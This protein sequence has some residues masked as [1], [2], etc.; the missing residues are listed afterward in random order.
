MAESKRTESLPQVGTCSSG[1]SHSSFLEDKPMD[2]GEG[3]DQLSFNND[4]VTVQ[5]TAME[6]EPGEI[7]DTPEVFSRSS[8]TARTPPNSST[9][10]LELCHRLDAD[11][12][13]PLNT[14]SAGDSPSLADV[15]SDSEITFT[16]MTKTEYNMSVRERKKAEG[17]WIPNRQWRKRKRESLSSPGEGSGVSPMRRTGSDS[18]PGSSQNPPP[19][20]NKNSNQSADGLVAGKASYRDQLVGHKL[21]VAPAAYPD[22]RFSVEECDLLQDKLM[23]LVFGDDGANIPH[24]FEK[25]YHEKGALVVTCGNSETTDWLKR[26]A[27]KLALGSEG[28]MEVI[29]ADYK[30][31]LRTT[32]VLLRT[33]RR[34]AKVEASKVFVQIERQNPGVTTK[35]WRVI[36]GKRKDDH[37]ILVLAIDEMNAQ[38]L[39]D[40]GWII[41]LGL[42]KIQLRVISGAPCDDPGPPSEPTT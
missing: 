37:Q 10:V 29:V 13:K 17:T 28:S 32:K 31:L 40:R 15:S 36:G 1:E 9:D 27:P 23:E 42:G 34:L 35:D 6:T 38:V 16:V 2:S 14:S 18:N 39:K 30:D 24:Q 21:A 11:L 26:V 19:K 3:N 41:Y 25:I 20:R 5:N 4:N 8:L 12:N 33:D 22:A 7:L